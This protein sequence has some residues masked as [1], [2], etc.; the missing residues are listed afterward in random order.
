[1]T[2][3]KKLRFLLVWPLA[4]WMFVAAR[5]TERQ[6]SIGLTFI[7]L[8]EGLRLWANSYVGH[9]KVNWTKRWRGDSKIGQL[10]TAGPYA[11]V[12]HPLYLGTFLIGAGFGIIAGN[13]WFNA[14]ALGF[15]L[16]VYRRKMAQ[17]ER[18]LGSEIGSPYLVYQAAVPRWVPTLK[19]YPNSQGCSSWQ[20]IMASK[21]WKTL[22]WVLVVVL[23]LY[24]REEMSEAD[25]LFP[26]DEWV[27]HT[28]LL[29][30]GLALMATDGLVELILRR[31][32][33]MRAVAR[34]ADHRQAGATSGTPR[35]GVRNRPGF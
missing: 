19:R 26:P 35:T 18:L 10:V 14:A 29:I 30:V 12:R 33:A 1:M 28:I 22:I 17:E 24:F 4:I 8:G 31:R 3:L 15:F 13:V 2:R 16:V 20:G 6:L 23:A 34:P 21:E 25:R 9:V 11:F 5:T 7:L 32:Q 27:K